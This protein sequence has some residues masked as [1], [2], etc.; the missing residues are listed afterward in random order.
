METLFGSL[1]YAGNKL[2]PHEW[3]KWKEEPEEST[4]VRF[5]KWYNAQKNKENHEI[6]LQK[7]RP[8]AKDEI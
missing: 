2:I 1:I 8:M 7:I 5:T 4:Q 6:Q 3:D